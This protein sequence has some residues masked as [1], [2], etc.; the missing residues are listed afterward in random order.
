MRGRRVIARRCEHVVFRIALLPVG[1]N[2]RFAGQMLVQA[3]C[4]G[5]SLDPE[6]H[7]VVGTLYLVGES[8]FAV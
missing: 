6:R 2:A 3:S 7:L 5:P 1:V 4:C 8:L